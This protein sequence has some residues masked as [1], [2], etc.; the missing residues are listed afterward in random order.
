MNICETQQ[1]VQTIVGLQIKK[2]HI[3]QRSNRN[4]RQGERRQ[5]LPQGI[6][7]PGRVEVQPRPQASPGKQFFKNS[8]FGGVRL[9]TSERGPDRFQKVSNTVCAAP[10]AANRFHT[11]LTEK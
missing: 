5:L 10:L 11:A 4:A 2:S 8:R 7:P 9:R 6:H 3:G 1:I